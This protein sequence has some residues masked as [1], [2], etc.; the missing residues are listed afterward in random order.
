MLLDAGADIEADEI[1]CYGGKPL[2]WASERQVEVVKLLLEHGAE[3]DSR[4]I[5]KQS[6]YYG[7][8]P[9]GMNVLMQD[10]C[11][12]VSR[13]LLD[14]GADRS[15]HFN[16]KSLIEIAKEKGN[17]KILEVLQVR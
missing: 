11:A 7:I 14:A 3:V 8:T 1:N 2:Q 13:L 6:T 15:F 10:D 9:L 17:L 4:N 5:D 12:E 16:G